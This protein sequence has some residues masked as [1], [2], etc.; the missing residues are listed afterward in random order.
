MKPSWAARSA[1]R[2]RTAPTTST[3]RWRDGDIVRFGAQTP[4]GARDAGPHR[5]LPLVRDRRPQ[6]VFTATRCS[7]AARGAPTSSR[8]TA[9]RLFRS[10]REQL[11]TLPDGCLGLSGPRLRGPHVEH[12]GEERALQPAHRRR[13]AR[14]GLRRLHEKPRPA[15]P[16]ADRRRRARPTCARASP[17]TAETRAVA[18]VGARRHDLRRRARRS[19]P[20]W[21]ALHRGEVRPRRPQPASSTASW[22]TSRTRSS[23]RSTTPRAHSR[24]SRPTSRSS[25]SVRPGSDPDWERRS[26]LRRGSRTSPTSRAAWSNGASSGYPASYRHRGSAFV[27]WIIAE[28]A[29]FPLTAHPGPRV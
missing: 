15:P 27:R 20:E 14:G 17:R 23:S 12:I 24:R 6:M 19:A 8:A 26:S 10:I 1:S 3:C 29:R 9:H 18:G 5:G 13:R 25:S 4:R 16:Q 7:C 21:V 22:D 2:R 28:G 11:F